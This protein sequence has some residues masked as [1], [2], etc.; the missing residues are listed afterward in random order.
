MGHCIRLSM[1]ELERL[2]GV[3]FEV[4]GKVL[5]AEREQGVNNLLIFNQPSS[6]LCSISFLLKMT[7]KAGQ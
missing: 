5:V 1:G 7:E 3:V 6:S 4:R 2:L